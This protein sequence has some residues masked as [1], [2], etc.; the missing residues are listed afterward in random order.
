MKLLL[1]ILEQA[2]IQVDHACNGYEAVH[3]IETSDYDVVLMDINMPGM[4]GFDVAHQILALRRTTVGSVRSWI[5]TNNGGPWDGEERARFEALRSVASRAL[6]LWREG[7]SRPLDAEV[8]RT[9]P[10]AKS[11]KLPDVLQLAEAVQWDARALL[12]ELEDKRVKGLREKLREELRHDL[13]ERGLLPSS[14]PLSEAT[15]RQSVRGELY[16]LDADG[17]LGQD[18]A[19]QTVLNLLGW[20]RIR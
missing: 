9:G 11:T 18:E 16:A 1:W 2:H 13:E 17:V 4:S 8:L 10:L 14:E 5:Q 15:V 6:A 19:E 20:L 12:E 7:R 3:A